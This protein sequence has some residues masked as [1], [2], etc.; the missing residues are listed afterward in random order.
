VLQVNYRGSGGYGT[1]FFDLGRHQVGGA[2]QQD[3]EDMTRWAVQQGVA[4]PRRLAIIGAS[5]GGYSTLVAL[6]QTPDLFRCGVACMA[7]SDWNGLFKYLKDEHQYSKDALRYWSSMLGDMRD[8]ARRESLAAVSPVNLA[9]R[10]KAPLF[11]MHGEE[12][13][14]V[15]LEQAHAMVAALK[16]A[17]HPPETLYLDYIGHFWPT[18]RKGEEFLQR[19]EAFLARNLGAP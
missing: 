2:I 15:P 3:I 18:S 5:Y 6:A 10:M 8:P 19:L 7:V 14:T 1:E 9:A 4:D 17:G 12:D 13:S 11:I 16:Q